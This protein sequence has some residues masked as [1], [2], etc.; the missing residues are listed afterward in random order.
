MEITV[1]KNL[2]IIDYNVTEF[3]YFKLNPF[4]PNGLDFNEMDIVVNLNN[5]EWNGNPFVFVMPNIQD[6]ETL[7]L[8]VKFTL[9][10]NFPSRVIPIIIAGN[11]I[12]IWNTDLSILG[13]T[14]AMTWTPQSIEPS[15]L[16]YGYW[17]IDYDQGSRLVGETRVVSEGQSTNAFS[18]IMASKIK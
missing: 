4:G 6:L 2:T 9:Y 17:F 18:D 7:N 15:S 10:Y 13:S 11:E 14:G 1:N 12:D 3:D 16:D 8:K 5:I